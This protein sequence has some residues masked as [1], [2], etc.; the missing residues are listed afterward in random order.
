[1]D[2]NFNFWRRAINIWTI[3]FFFLI[4]L[5]FISDNEYND[6]LNLISVVYI[7]LLAVYA[8]HK[9]FSR[10]YDKH[11][12]QHPGEI[13]VALWSALFFVLIGLD[14]ILNKPYIL[15]DSVASAFIAVLTILVITAQS[16]QLYDVRRSGVKTNKKRYAKQKKGKS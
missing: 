6:W 2:H 1:M 5:D 15:P 13:F 12:G 14:F 4:I 16:K 3:I 9:E 7:A 11:K 8:G 10:W